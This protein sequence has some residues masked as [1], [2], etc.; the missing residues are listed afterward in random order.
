M[1]T[2]STNEFH[3]Q[4]GV[5]PFER[6]KE[7]LPSVTLSRQYRCVADCTAHTNRFMYSGQVE[8]N[9]SYK[10]RP[11]ARKFINMVHKLFGKE[12]STCYPSSADYHIDT[13]GTMVCSPA[14]IQRRGF[15]P[16]SMQWKRRS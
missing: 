15:F 7:T 8:N 6:L 4:R 11:V 13:A 2:L 10:E 12:K 1:S 16:S 14:R 3:V 5:S 9:T